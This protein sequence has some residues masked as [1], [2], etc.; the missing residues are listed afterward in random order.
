M[1]A[2]L[3]MS[4]DWQ[5][6]YWW[7][8]N[9]ICVKQVSG[10]QLAYSHLYLNCFKSPQRPLS[11]VATKL[12]LNSIISYQQIISKWSYSYD[13]LGFF[14]I[15]SRTAAKPI[16]DRMQKRKISV[17]RQTTNMV[18][19]KKFSGLTKQI[20]VRSK[21]ACTAQ[22]CDSYLQIWNYQ[23]LTHWL[24][25]SLTHWLTGVGARRCYRI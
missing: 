19:E 10:S 17:N 14:C 24:T 18:P 13:W 15:Q 8:V 2:H 22:R 20:L 25:D 4:P 16:F 11:K 7:E 6:R 12:Q 5:N 3:K 1:L 23:S 21:Q 9:N